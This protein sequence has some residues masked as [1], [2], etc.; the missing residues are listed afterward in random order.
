MPILNK[1][2][3]NNSLSI[4]IWHIVESK[5]NLLETYI[6]RGF[7][8]N[9]VIDTKSE[10]RLKQWLAIRLLLHEF[11]QEAKISY[12]GFGKPFLSNKVEISISH[13]GDFAVIALNTSKKCGIDIEK[14][15]SKVERIKYK[16]L[17]VQELEIAKTLE[18]LTL[19]WCAK[20]A[21]YKL[22]GDK[23]LIF[24]EQLFVSYKNEPKTIKG[25]I[26]TSATDEQH[27]LI[28]EKIDDYLLV[29]TI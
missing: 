12:N 2:N 3:I 28:A 21:L 13:A 10:L 24:N 4:G 1:K 14:I 15:S 23:E 17:N 29:Y 26:K 19:F 9:K 25:R 22:Y 16:F 5:E 8:V 6:D 18:E 7:D 20:E 11:Y 27:E